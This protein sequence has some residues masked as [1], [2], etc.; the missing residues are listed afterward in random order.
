MIINLIYNI[1]ENAANEFQDL[2]GLVYIKM[3]FGRYC[4]SVLLK[5]QFKTTNDMSNNKIV[6]T[7]KLVIT[8]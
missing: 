1:I 4:Y 6:N 7:L 3:P 2:K 8:G 5:Y